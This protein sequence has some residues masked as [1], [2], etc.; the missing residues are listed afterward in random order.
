MADLK[1]KFFFTRGGSGK[2]ARRAGLTARQAGHRAC[3]GMVNVVKVPRARTITKAALSQ[4]RTKGGFW[5][6]L[7]SNVP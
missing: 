7:F 3:Q 6:W 1:K 5:F 4:P 2:R